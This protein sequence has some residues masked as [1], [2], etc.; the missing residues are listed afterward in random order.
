MSWLYLTLCAMLSG[1]HINV[2]MWFWHCVF[3]ITVCVTSQERWKVTSYEILFFYFLKQ[4]CL[5]PFKHLNSHL[6]FVKK[7]ASAAL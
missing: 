2:E 1:M 6:F 7:K 5:F 3:D 4:K